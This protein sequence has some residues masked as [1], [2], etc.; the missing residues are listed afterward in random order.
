MVPVA[1]FSA[2]D[3]APGRLGETLR[4]SVNR[5]DRQG[6][7]RLLAITPTAVTKLASDGAELFGY[8][9]AFTNHLGRIGQITLEQF[10]EMF[11]SSAAYLPGISWNPLLAPNAPAL[12]ESMEWFDSN[13]NDAER[14]LLKTNGFVASER[15]GG[16]R[17]LD[18]FSKIWAAGVP[19]FISTDALLQ[20]W[21]RTY[22]TMLE[23]IEETFLFNS[24]ETMLADMAAQVVSTA[25]GTSP[26]L[27]ELSWTR[28][29]F[30]PWPGRCSPAFRLPR[31]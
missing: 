21:H 15:L 11:P 3:S 22:D 19:V 29:I 31:C 20:A 10:R 27:R 2:N 5:D 26:A 28:T 25:G 7:Y 13:L 4:S 16:A 6:F 9:E 30:W 23:E 18:V 8:A 1:V 24:F 14:S 12:H 17:F